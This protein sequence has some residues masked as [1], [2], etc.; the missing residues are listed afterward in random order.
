MWRSLARQP[1][2]AWCSDDFTK[3]P[4]EGSDNT[5]GIPF[6]SGVGIGIGFGAGLGIILG[7]VV[8]ALTQNAVWIGIGI[9]FGAGLGI[10]VGAVFQANRP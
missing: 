7:T 2:S 3:D 8:S 9:T 1:S 4:N 10:V 5:P 6:G